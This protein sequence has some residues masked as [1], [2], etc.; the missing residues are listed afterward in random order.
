MTIGVLWEFFE[1]SADLLLQT[2]MQK[3]TVVTAISSV[4]LNPAA[5]NAAVKLGGITETVVNG[6]ALPIAGPQQNFQC[7]R[8]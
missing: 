3:D 2:D 1:F 8:Y 4:L 7:N 6:E 5:T